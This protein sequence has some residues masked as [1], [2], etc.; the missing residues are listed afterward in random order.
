M[1]DGALINL[2]LSGG[3]TQPPQGR[4]MQLRLARRYHTA[5]LD[6]FT[7]RVTQS[8]IVWTVSGAEGLSRLPSPVRRGREVNLMWSTREEAGRWMT[9]FCRPRLNPI[10]LRNVFE[11][12]FPKLR[13]L[14]RL[15]GPDW[16]ASEPVE[17]ECEPADM[18][19][20]LQAEGLKLFLEEAMRTGAVWLLEDDMG[21][22]FASSP[23]DRTALVLPCW[24]NRQGAEAQ[25]TGFWSEMM[26]S[27]VEL[28]RFIGR[29]L[30]WL[31][32]TGRRAAPNHNLGAPLEHSPQDMA[33]H[34][35]QAGRSG[36]A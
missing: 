16:A 4:D 17:L 29:T 28:D 24:S 3:L 6:T 27:R 19:R 22:A 7:R 10:T 5:T 14:N 20:R 9:R 35:K 32:E 12:V 23:I 33:E 11:D 2:R 30:P 21:P 15:L 25:C 13:S 31:L 8:R 1:L 34:F 36:A 26:I 18:E